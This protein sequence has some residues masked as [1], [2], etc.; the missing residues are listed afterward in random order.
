MNERQSRLPLPTNG[1]REA[2][3]TLAEPELPSHP[4]SPTQASSERLNWRV[5]LYI[6]L[7]VA[8]AA[9]CVWYYAP[10]TTTEGWQGFVALIILAIVFERVGIQIYGETH[11]SAGVVALFA[12]S[13]LYGAPGVTIAAPLVVLAA[14]TRTRSP[15]YG[16][17]FDMS[18]YT[19]ANVAS[20]LVFHVL[21]DIDSGVDGW[22]VPAAIIAIAANY[23]VNIP[24]VS[25]EVSLESGE[26]SVAV[27]REQHQWLVPYYLVFGLLAL[28]LATAYAA[29]GVWGIMAFVAPPL[30]MRFALHQ[31]V[32]KTEQTV[33][34]LKQKN[35]QLE[36][37]NSD[38]LEMTR[39]LTETYGGTLEA[40]VLA[41]DAR[42]RETKGHSLRVADY[43]MAVARE[44]GMREGSQE[45]VD[46]QRGALLHDVGKIG[47][48]DQILHKP[49]PL[50]PEE[51][52]EMK[53]HPGI[54]HEMLHDIAFLSGAAE[55]VHAHHERFDGKGYPRGLLG[56]EIPLGARIFAIG[57]TLDAMTSDRPYR[58]ALPAEV[59]RWEIL[60]HSGTQFDPQVVQAFL[61]VF[62]QLA[63]K[64]EEDHEGEHVRAA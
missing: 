46:T 45:W 3:E 19:L 31:F 20:A 9:L 55:I 17:F 7:V 23:A 42:D 61:L 21:I 54:G 37:A 52:D 41:L 40:L 12:I 59:A 48:P 60:R 15:W 30:M 64:A 57:D 47:V 10:R 43:V 28:A 18:S 63:K 36:A 1:Q 22:W 5:A 27:W 32:N 35:N 50:T 26:S 34:E 11:V 4:V 29:L 53:R 51:W 39:Q 24:I 2:G 6:A 13:I 14:E 58:K 33:L 38:I 16:R 25:I 56:D 62:D 44:L 49:G 8:A